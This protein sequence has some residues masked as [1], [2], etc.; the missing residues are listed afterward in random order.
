ME[1]V[2]YALLGL[3]RKGDA[4]GYSLRRTFEECTGSVWELNAG[5]VYQT[6]HNLERCSLVAGREDRCGRGQ[7]RRVFRITAKGEDVLDAWLSRNPRWPFA[8]RD[9]LLIRFV[10]SEMAKFDTNQLEQQRARYLDHLSRLN[11]R[12]DEVRNRPVGRYRRLAALAIEGAILRTEAHLNWLA[13]CRQMLA[14]EARG[15]RPGV[16]DDDVTCGPRE[17]RK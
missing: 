11:A 10:L 12:R 2:G 13:S 1:V 17:I 5:Q 7:A 8:F 14:A 9:E 3:L 15:T 4:H 16:P 6:L